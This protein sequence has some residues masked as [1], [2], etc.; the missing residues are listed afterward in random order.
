MKLEHINKKQLLDYL[1][2]DGGDGWTI[3]LPSKFT[4]M[5]FDLK[6]LPVQT[7]RSDN[8]DPKLTITKDG[9]IVNKL[10]GIYNLSF[11][12][13]LAASVGAD[14]KIAAFGRGTQARTLTERILSKLEQ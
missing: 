8:S 13:K 10:T 2:E 5:G 12:Y 3:W 11:L 7:F 4:D 6:D 9:K 14:T 1:K